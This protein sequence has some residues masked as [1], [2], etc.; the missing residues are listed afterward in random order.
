[1]DGTWGRIA[2]K[3]R[4]DNFP[5]FREGVECGLIVWSYGLAKEVNVIVWCGVMVWRIVLA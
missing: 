5:M 4:E 1:M 3:V 2:S